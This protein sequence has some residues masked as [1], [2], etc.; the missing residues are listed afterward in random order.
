MK[1]FSTLATALLLALLAKGQPTPTA[2][3]IDQWIFPTLD[4]K[5]DNFKE[6]FLGRYGVNGYTE[7]QMDVE[8]YT[9]YEGTLELSDDKQAMLAYLKNGIANLEE[10]G[11]ESSAALHFIMGS[12]AYEIGEKE[13]AIEHYVEAI[14]KHPSFL[15]AYANLGFSLMETDHP[16]KALPVLL[17]A[18]EL[19][20]NES[21]IHGLVGHIYLTEKLYG[22][23]L[24][25]FELALVFNP[26]NNV[27]RQGALRCLTQLDRNQEA[28]QVLDEMTAF[29]R[30]APSHYLN[31]ASLLLR[32]DRPDEAIIDLQLAHEL[33][34]NTASSHLL[35][36]NLLYN[37][38][39]YAQALDN[40]Q[41]TAALAQAPE[42]FDR[43]LETAA[44]M[45]Q[46]EGGIFATQLLQTLKQQA[47]KTEQMLDPNKIAKIEVILAITAGEYDR[48]LQRI[49]QLIHEMPT[50]GELQLIKAEAA[51]HLNQYTTAA[52]AYELAATNEATAYSALYAHARL[53][54]GR[55]ELESALSLL[56]KAYRTEPNEP[57]L[58][59]IREIENLADR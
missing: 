16:E 9:L 41:K 20:A 2:D 39:L 21:Q 45:T 3:L 15:R 1:T 40:F 5:E 44:S 11:I 43:L 58:S 29:D 59:Y 38:G 48:V 23:A 10:S 32:L 56:R 30:K 37:K 47:D 52:L 34:G 19:G 25:S 22:S 54:L 33:N 18:I 51:A 27:W 31:R 53:E 24:T 57:L 35:L 28:I 26:A 13:A 49:D 36:G 50:D 4:W 17:K 14:R 12:V 46:I 6:R 7:P 8:N 55:G 42:L